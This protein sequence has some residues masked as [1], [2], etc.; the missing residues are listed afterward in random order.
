MLQLAPIILFV[1][2]R[3]WHTG[4]TLDALAKNELANESVL[5]IY[6]DGAKENATE[7]DLQKIKEV[8]EII[9]TFEGCKE[10]HIIEREKNWGLANNVIE[11]ITKIVNQYKKIIVLEDD[12]IT[13]PFFLDFMNQGLDLYKD[14]QKVYGITG[15]SFFPN[16]KLPSTFLLPLGSSW[17]WA[18]WQRAWNDFESDAE[19]L[20]QQI[21]S[22]QLEKEFNF[23]AY[24]Y[25]QMLESQVQ[26]KIDS[27]AIRF[28]ASY[29]LQN[30]SFLVPNQ[31]LV[32]NIGMDASGTH[33][34]EEIFDNQ[35]LVT[36]KYTVKKIT[37]TE[38][39]RAIYF[40]ESNFLEQFSKNKS[41]KLN[42]FFEKIKSFIK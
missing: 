9:S 36:Q 11:G 37:K 41:K 33:C 21:K 23:G 27:W 32:Y 17:G 26:K 22:Q 31:N 35:Q 34:E 3:P 30:A 28:Y 10:T 8:R 20:V 12:L 38:S 19:K 1:Y 13:S 40:I 39:K 29:F 6:A 24:P 42:T 16:N 2:N 4:Q 18:T 25:F 5:Y 14:E 15:Y 7:I